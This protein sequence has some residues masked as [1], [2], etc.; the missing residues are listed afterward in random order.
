[1]AYIGVYPTRDQVRILGR[2]HTFEY[3]H[4]RR[5]GGAAHCK[6]CGVYIFGNVYGPDPSVFDK[7]PPERREVVLQIY[8]KNMALQPVNVRAIEGLDLKSIY[9]ERT[10]SGTE[11]YMLDE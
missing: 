9:V 3:T 11:G 7:L 1:M 2:E 8:H 4:G 5:F 6:D 10:D